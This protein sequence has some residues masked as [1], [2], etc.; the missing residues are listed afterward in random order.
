[1]AKTDLVQKAK[2]ILAA[3]RIPHDWIKAGPYAVT[4]PNDESDERL[5]N[6]CE[7]LFEKPEH[8]RIAK[9]KVRDLERKNADGKY[10]W[11]DARRTR[12]ENAP[13]RMIHQ[14]ADLLRDYFI[15]EK[16]EID[17]RR[18]LKNKAVTNKGVRL[19]TLRGKTWQWAQAA[20]TSISGPQ[21]KDFELAV[22]DS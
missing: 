20:T 11:L 2:E 10:C 19:V 22:T 12:T 15:A 16:V 5:G 14:M 4:R 17:M 13:A 6:S 8:L 3:A 18:D 7:V 1:M 9:H 21:R